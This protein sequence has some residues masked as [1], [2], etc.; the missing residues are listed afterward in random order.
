MRTG[1]R[2][3]PGSVS[4]FSG[5][6]PSCCLVT[7]HGEFITPFYR[8]GREIQR[9]SLSYKWW[10]Q[11]LNSGAPGSQAPAWGPP[12]S[13]GVGKPH[14]S[15]TSCGVRISHDMTSV[16]AE[17]VF[18]LFWKGRPAFGME[19]EPQTFRTLDRGAHASSL[20][21]TLEHEEKFRKCPSLGSTTDQ[22]SGFFL[23]YF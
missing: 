1:V 7:G 22:R 3:G 4:A 10:S 15:G 5:A 19:A 9:G 23:L 12:V 11:G 2:G 8:W 13:K 18:L 20:A 14:P 16:P 6:E 21:P 17:R